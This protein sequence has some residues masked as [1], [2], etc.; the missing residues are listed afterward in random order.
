MRE[1][2]ERFQVHVILKNISN[3]FL[4]LKMFVFDVNIV[5]LNILDESKNL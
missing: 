1:G 2:H 4:M 3:S 5:T